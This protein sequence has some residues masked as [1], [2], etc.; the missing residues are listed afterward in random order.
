MS[1]Q[2]QQTHQAGCQ[3][4]KACEVVALTNVTVVPLWDQPWLP[5]IM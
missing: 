1:L 5:H 2:A 4:M 3:V